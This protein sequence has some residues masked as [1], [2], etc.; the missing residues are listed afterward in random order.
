L[1]SENSLSQNTEEDKNAI[2]CQ[3]AAELGKR[4]R[5]VAKIEKETPQKPE[6]KRIKKMSL[7]VV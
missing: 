2:E 1:K 3:L 7:K 6:K 4:K 5:V